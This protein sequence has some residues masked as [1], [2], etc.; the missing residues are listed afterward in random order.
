MKN[1]FVILFLFVFLN[2]FAIANIQSIDKELNSCLNGLTDNISMADCTLKA[3]KNAELEIIQIINKNKISHPDFIQ[4][5]QLWEKYKHSTKTAINNPLEKNSGTMYFLF[6]SNSQYNLN[7]NR[8]LFLEYF[9]NKQPY[10]KNKYVSEQFEFCLNKNNPVKCYETDTIRLS[11]QISNTLKTLQTTLSDNEYSTL[12][13]N[14]SDWLKYKNNTTL[15]LKKNI[16]E[17]QKAQ[18]I[19]IIYAERNSQLFALSRQ[20]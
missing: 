4:N 9:L 20:Q 14:Q 10:Q 19:N 2:T 11:G 8:L 12:K 17:L 3:S 13:D 7:K 5:Q 1:F 18:I 6:S 16:T 15:L